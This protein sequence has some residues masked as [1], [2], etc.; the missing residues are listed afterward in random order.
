MRKFTKHHNSGFIHNLGIKSETFRNH[1]IH[2]KYVSDTEKKCFQCDSSD[3]LK[4]EASANVTDLFAQIPSKGENVGSGQKDS[5]QEETSKFILD[6]IPLC[7]EE[8]LELIAYY[9][10]ND[11]EKQSN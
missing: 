4:M 3:Q 8:D 7:C 2:G 6:Y 11:K 9:F 5:K 10:G 1:E